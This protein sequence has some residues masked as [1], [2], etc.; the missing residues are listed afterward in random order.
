MDLVIMNPPFT[1]DSLRHDQFSGD[2]EEAIKKREKEVF[3]SHPTYMAGNSGAFLV[4]ANHLIKNDASTLAAILPLVSITDKS[5]F[6]IRK[7]LA[8]RF[9]IDTIVS[10]HD[11]T[12]I[13]FSENTRHRRDSSGLPTVEQ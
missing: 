3:A 11:P 6:Q 10:S 4:L 7:Y 13:F 9:H 5:G 8:E 2:D 12:R 1:R